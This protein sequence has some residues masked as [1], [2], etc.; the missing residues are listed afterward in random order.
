M[1]FDYIWE[2]KQSN[3]ISQLERHLYLNIVYF[4]YLFTNKLQLARICFITISLWVNYDNYMIANLFD[5]ASKIPVIVILISRDINQ[6]IHTKF[7]ESVFIHE[8][9]LTDFRGLSN[10]FVIIFILIGKILISR[11]PIRPSNCMVLWFT[12]KG[13]NL[14]CVVVLAS[15][16][17]NTLN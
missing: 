17:I 14:G 15:I 4:S 7:I 9:I 12:L 3:S 16:I 11:A 6:V 2:P 8:L 5:S 1:A 13:F 10:Y